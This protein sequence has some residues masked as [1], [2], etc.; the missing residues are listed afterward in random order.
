MLQ[1]HDYGGYKLQLHDDGM[2]DSDTILRASF[3]LEL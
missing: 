3:S 1:L 2:V